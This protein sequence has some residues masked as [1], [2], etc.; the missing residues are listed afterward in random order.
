MSGPNAEFVAAHHAAKHAPP[1]L[2]KCSRCDIQ[3][4]GTDAMDAHL[5]FHT[6]KSQV[7]KLR[8][9]ENKDRRRGRPKARYECSQCDFTTAKRSAYLGHM[10][11]HNGVY[12]TCDVD[13]CSYKSTERLNYYGHKK[14]IH[15]A[16][17]FQC[18]T[19]G[20]QT[21]T[22]HRLREHMNVHTKEKPVQ[23]LLCDFRCGSRSL[24]YKHNKT[25][26]LQLT[27]NSRIRKMCE[28]CGKSIGQ[29]S[30]NAHMMRHLGTQPFKCEVEGC[31]YAAPDRRH[32]TR[33]TA[34]VH[35]PD[36]QGGRARGPRKLF[37]YGQ[38]KVNESDSS[39]QI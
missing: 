27:L 7:D 25:V 38:S 17:N 18:A 37:R 22:N 12:Y 30:L 24:L 9:D 21:T 16:K 35:P 36:G 19:C 20:Y 15:G 28:I 39:M 23:C 4:R 26:H 31:S 29:A 10:N 3:T 33:H 13:G 1:L 11:E 8:D 2:L 32:L 6:L 5:Q 14:L 34:Q